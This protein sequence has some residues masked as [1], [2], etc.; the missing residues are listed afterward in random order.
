MEN[1]IF[2]LITFIV[3]YLLYFIFVISKKNKL[4]KFENSMYV[5]FLV[6]I[7]KIDIKKIDMKKLAHILAISNSFILAFTVFI[8]E[9]VDKLF[10]KLLVGFVVILPLLYITYFI[11]GKIL[12]NKGKKR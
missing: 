1:I 6:N 11:I 8:V 9:Y 12:K 5:N 2:S 10:L 4:E 7:S 3:I